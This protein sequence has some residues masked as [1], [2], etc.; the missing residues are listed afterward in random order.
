MQHIIAVTAIDRVIAAAGINRVIACARRDDV[1][2]LIAEQAVIAAAGGDVFD[3]D[4]R[5]DIGACYN[6]GR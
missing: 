2:C 3:I 6:R 4:E 1:G 5:V